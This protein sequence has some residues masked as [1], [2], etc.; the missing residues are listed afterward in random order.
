MRRIVPVAVAASLAGAGAVR[1]QH[2]LRPPPLVLRGRVAAADGSPVAGV[3]VWV[4]SGTFADSADVDPA[5]AYAFPLQA[6][7]RDSVEVRVG[8]ADTARAAFL[9][10]YGRVDRAELLFD[11]GFVLVPRRWTVRA[12]PYAG[13]VVEMDLPRAFRPSCRACSSFFRF[14]GGRTAATRGRVLSWPAQRFPLRVAFD[15]DR[16]GGPQL[17]ARDSAAFWRAAR[18]ME[19]AVGAELFRPSSYADALPREGAADDVVLVR[20][21]PALREA[22]LTTVIS[23]AAGITYGAVRVQRA[24]VLSEEAGGRLVAHELLHAIG[25][26][27]TCSWR[28]VMSEADACPGLRADAPTP[29][30]VAYVQMLLRVLALQRDPAL[31]WGIEAA[32]DAAGIARPDDPVVGP[33]AARDSAGAPGSTVSLLPRLR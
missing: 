20:A 23:G 14:R 25:I 22:G 11:V 7:G 3:R 2:E 17:T 8:S 4:R 33:Q 13:Q 26:G 18:A 16:Q 12:G 6:G 29:E 9:P 24:S 5:G 10:A 21:D 28:S 19:D 30:D 32:L 31:R 1:A 27:H 15:R